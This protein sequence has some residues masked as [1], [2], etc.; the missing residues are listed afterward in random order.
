MNDERTND[1]VR[2]AVREQYGSVAPSGGAAQLAR[3]GAVVPDR[4]PA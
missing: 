2:V 3:Q 4:R 1:D